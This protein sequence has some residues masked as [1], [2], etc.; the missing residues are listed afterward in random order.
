MILSFALCRGWWGLPVMGFDGIAAGTVIAY[1]AGGVIQ[2]VV[3]LRPGGAVRLYVH[4]LQ[5]HWVTIKRLFRIGVP[6]AVEGL[7]AWFANFGVIAIINKADPTNVMSAA[8]MNTIRI[9]SISFLSGIAFAT[10]AATMVG[11]SLGMKDPNR[12]RRSAYLAFAVGGGIMVICGLLMITIGRYPARW[13]SPDDPQIIRLTTTCLFITGFI[14]SGF[15]A[16]LIFGGA[17]RGAGDT[18]VVMVINLATT[19]TL[20]F[21]GVIVVGLWMHAGLAAIWCVLAGELF[22]RGLLV[23]LRFLHGGWLRIEV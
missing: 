5:P 21:G 23:Y 1:V 10:A 4:R 9:E 22:T 16:N 6:A 20:R 17:L 12:A 15:A 18:L 14:Q 3:L 8:H 7:L 19:L 11:M 13:L 2:F